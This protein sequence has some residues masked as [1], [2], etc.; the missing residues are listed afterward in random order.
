[1]TKR[2]KSPKG[3]PPSITITLE[4]CMGIKKQV[5][6]STP[7][8]FSISWPVDVSNLLGETTA[9]MLSTPYEMEMRV[10]MSTQGAVYRADHSK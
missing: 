1:M 3:R 2:K 4:D 10:T 6:V 9:V 7:K 8:D 5:W